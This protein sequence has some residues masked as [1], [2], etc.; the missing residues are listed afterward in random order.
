MANKEWKEAKVMEYILTKTQEFF[1]INT[2]KDILEDF[3]DYLE[4]S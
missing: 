3:L 1:D 4:E 2:H